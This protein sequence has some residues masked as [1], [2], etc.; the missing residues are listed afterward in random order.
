MI[1]ITGAA[2]FIGSYLTG[3]LNE[4]G[5]K[6]LVLV[7]DFSSE[8]KQP[9]WESKAYSQK[10]DRDNF[11]SWLHDNQRLVQF[12]FH[13]GARTDTAENDEELF[14]KLNINYT[15]E[16]WQACCSYGIPLVYA[17][18]AATYGDGS[19]GYSDDHQWPGKLEPLNAY[20]RSKNEFD[21]WA[22]QQTEKPRFWAGLKFFNVYGP[23]EF[24]KGRMASV[25]YHAYHQYKNNGEVKLFRSHRDDVADG[26]QKRDFIYVHDVAKICFWLMHHRKPEN[27]GLYNVGTGQAETFLELVRGL[28]DALN[29]EENIRFIDT[30]ADIRENYQYYTCADTNKLKK[31]GYDRRFTLLREGVKDYVQHFLEAGKYY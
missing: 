23:N 8:K 12:I 29:V 24:H 14:E 10:I 19:L 3:F 27:N 1:V 16:I 26:E 6:D 28:F 2:G 7:D 15:K 4:E 25:I 9:N 17:S 31:A 30:P 5:Y 22:L 20:G 13:I 11:I 18:S 21:K